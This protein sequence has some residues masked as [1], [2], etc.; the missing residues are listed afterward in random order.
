MRL[1]L[2]ILI[3]IGITLGA[4]YLH[5]MNLTSAPAG[6]TDGSQATAPDLAS[7]PVVNWEVLNAITHDSTEWVRAQWNK[8]VH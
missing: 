4:A 1:I 8:L 7:R 3:G 2:G 5:D 6:A